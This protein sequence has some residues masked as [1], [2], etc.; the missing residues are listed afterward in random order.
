MQTFLPFSSFKKSARVL[1][2]KRLGKQRVEVLQ[3]L[4]S[5]E[6]IKTNQPFKGWKNHPA[7]KMWFNGE[8]DYTN[9]LVLYGLTICKEWI[10]RGYNDTTKQKISKFF[11]KT[12]PVIYPE[13]IGDER[14]H[15][16]HRSSLIRKKP[17]YYRK[18]FPKTGEHLDYFWPKK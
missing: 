13:F 6:K 8:N 10:R 1:D 17:D 12:K 2:Y 9:A 11:D 4:N 5:I 15:L 3:L 14:F 7:R 16:S 18:L